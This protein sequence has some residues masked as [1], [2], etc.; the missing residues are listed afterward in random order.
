MSFQDRGDASV[1]ASSSDDDDDDD[2][3]PILT[4]IRQQIQDDDVKYGKPGV[5]VCEAAANGDG[6]S[7]RADAGPGY[8]NSCGTSGGGPKGRG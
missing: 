2:D 4:R 3:D 1:S 5:D 6:R 8:P 7:T